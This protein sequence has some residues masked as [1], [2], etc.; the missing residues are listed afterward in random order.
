[1]LANYLTNNDP[2]K[3][4]DMMNEKSKELSMTNTKWFNASGAAAVAFKGYYSCT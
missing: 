3:W 4:L 1:M 2:D